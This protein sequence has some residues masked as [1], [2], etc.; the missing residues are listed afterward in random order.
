MPSSAEHQE[1]Y[2][3]NRRFLDANGGLAANEP[4]WAAVV[5][6]YAALHLVERLAARQNLHHTQGGAH[7][8]RRDYL[9]A[10]LQHRAILLPYRALHLAS[11][12]ARYHT[13][14]RFR[15]AYSP[16]MVQSLLIDTHLVAIERHVQTIFQPP[17]SGT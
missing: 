14:N 3:E 15:Q 6:F 9:K 17:A 7:G 5:A 13:L 4:V 8:A 12:I 10:H 2:A 11:E 16:A 1:K